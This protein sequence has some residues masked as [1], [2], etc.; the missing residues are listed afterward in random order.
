M[1]TNQLIKAIGEAS[2]NTKPAQEY[3]LFWLDWWPMCMT[4]SEWSGWVQAF[5]S[6]FAIFAVFL[7]AYYQFA[8]QRRLAAKSAH[9]IFT[10]VMAGLVAF[11]HALNNDYFD[12]RDLFY[13]RLQRSLLEDHLSI[14]KGIAFQDIGIGYK[15]LLLATRA[16]LIQLMLALDEADSEA[17]EFGNGE[18]LLSESSNSLMIEKLHVIME[19]HEKSIEMAAEI[20]KSRGKVPT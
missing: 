18:K 7:L 20:V 16:T 11:K 12:G 3:C 14:C 6:I 8:Q 5:G 9:T 1:D 13:V 19:K 4:K 2:A 15:E 17:I 10:K